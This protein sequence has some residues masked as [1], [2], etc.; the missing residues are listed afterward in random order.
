V[1]IFITRLF[2]SRRKAPWPPEGPIESV[3]D[4]TLMSLYA[5]G[6]EGAFKVLLGRHERGVYNF[7][8]RSVR[9]PARAE[10]LTQDV[11]F[12]VI[13]SAAKYKASA[14][15]TTWLYTIARNICIDQSR[16]KATKLEVSLDK[17]IG[18]GDAGG[19]GRTFLDTVTAHNAQ[20]GGVEVVKQE[21]RDRLKTALEALP[22]EQ[23][24]VFLLREVSG[25][26]FREIADVVGVPENTVKSRMRYA[27]ST[28]Q[29]YL[30]EF[31][32][33]SFDKDR[34]ADVGGA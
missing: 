26:K 18:R 14:R 24:E 17:P 19:A 27:L 5:G 32:G 16:R 20:S 33:Y 28:L 2:G 11:F 8:L 25:L 15:F 3:S 12:R 1:L 9:V 23:R 10:E 22:E 13:R 31:R 21:F 34:A 6:A 4:E 29:G 30:E 7:I